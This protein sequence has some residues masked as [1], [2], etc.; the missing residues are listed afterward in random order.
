MGMGFFL[1]HLGDPTMDERAG[2]H[3]RHVRVN[4]GALHLFLRSQQGP[5][6]TLALTGLLFLC[7]LRLG[8]S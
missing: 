4:V 3:R 7:S 5:E 8:R 2:E 6:R 1:S